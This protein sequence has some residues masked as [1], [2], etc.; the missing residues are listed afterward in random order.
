M[1]AYFSFMDVFFIGSVAIL[2]WFII[3]M[4][5]LMTSRDYPCTFTN[6]PKGIICE[7]YDEEIGGYRLV[8]IEVPYSIQMILKYSEDK[9][10]GYLDYKFSV[11]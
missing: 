3:E 6:R 10:Y 4:S 1:L 11:V 5:K 8:Q 7:K 9:S 2:L